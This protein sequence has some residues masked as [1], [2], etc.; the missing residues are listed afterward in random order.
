MV[1]NSLT[2]AL[3]PSLLNGQEEDAP[4]KPE[5]KDDTEEDTQQDREAEPDEA[6]EHGENGANEQTSLLPDRVA[7]EGSRIQTKFSKK[8]QKWFLSLPLAAQSTLAVLYQF[9]NA[10][11]I[12]AAIGAIIGLAP[13][14]HRVF[15]ADT[16]NGGFFNAWLTTSISNIGN[17]F[18]SLQVIVVGVKLGSSLRKMKRGEASGAVPWKAMAFVTVIRFVLWPA[19]SIPTGLVSSEKN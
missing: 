13:P 2:F 19:I 16:N 14:L 8:G 18:A 3:G 12:G 9:A 5:G 1:S 17:L 6:D 7:E 4:D 15:F 11:L 10:P